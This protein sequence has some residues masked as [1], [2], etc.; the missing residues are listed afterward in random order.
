[1]PDFFAHC[2]IGV[3]TPLTWKRKRGRDFLVA[4]I[5]STFPDIDAFFSSL[6]RI[7]LHSVVILIP[8][9]IIVDMI[10]KKYGYRVY[11]RLSLSLLPLI[12]VIMDLSTRGIPVKILFP[13]VDYGYQFSWLLDSI[14]INLLQLSPYSYF[15]EVIR[16]DL[17]LLLVVLFLIITNSL[18][19]KYIF[20]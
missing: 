1:L 19:C 5:L 12:H 13:L 20:D 2:L 17:V 11:Q 10:L 3:I 15:I 4:V 14:I 8:L 7:L 16:V 18:T 6:H 9:I